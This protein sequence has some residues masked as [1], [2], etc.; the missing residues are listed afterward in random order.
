VPQLRNTFLHTCLVLG[1]WLP[2][3]LWGQNGHAF[4][5]HF[6]RKEVPGELTTW[7]ISA[8]R[9]DR[10]AAANG[11]GLL[12]HAGG[13]WELHQLPNQA[14]ARS[15]IEISDGRWMVGGQGYVGL[16]TIGQLGP[17]T[18]EDRT[19]K[20]V[21][22]M[23]SF[24]D[25]WKI[26]PMPATSQASEEQCFLYTSGFVGLLTTSGAFEL[27]DAG[28]ISRGF[29]WGNDAVGWQ[30]GDSL[31][32]WADGTVTGWEV[33]KGVLVEAALTGPN[34][35][36]TLFT[37]DNGIVRASGGDD[38]VWS[39]SDSELSQYLKANRTRC[40]IQTAPDRWW[41]GTSRGGLIETS[42]LQSIESLY[43][44]SSGLCN[45]AV[46]SISL[47]DQGNLWVATEGGI[48][49]VRLAW[50]VTRAAPS[51]IGDQPGFAS[52]HDWAAGEIYWGTSQGLYVEDMLSGEV[53][54]V[55]AVAGP[56]W[57]IEKIQEELWIGH[58]NG[59]GHLDDQRQY[60]PVIAGV[61]VWGVWTS[62]DG[63][64]YAGTFQG[65]QPIVPD[66]ANRFLAKP[67][68]T[69][70][71][72]SSR[73]MRFDADDTLWVSH[74]YK[75][76]YR[77]AILEEANEVEL[78]H[79]YGSDDGFPEP[80]DV[81]LRD[82]DGE[83][84]FATSQG[85]CE[86]NRTTNRMELASGNW[87]EWLDPQA[88]FG[89]IES[90]KRGN[91]WAFSGSV[92][93]RFSAKREQ[94]NAA[95]EVT[96]A[97]F[98]DALA[99]DGF[100]KIEFL[101]D[102]RVCSPTETGFVYID[103]ASML[104]EDD[105]PI[106]EVIQVTHLNHPNGSK[107]LPLEDLHLP[108]GSHALQIALKSQDSR[109]TGRLK[110][111]WRIPEVSAEWSTP[112][113]GQTIALN[114]LQPGLHRVE[115]RALIDASLTG[116]SQSITI[117]IEPPWFERWSVRVAFFLFTMMLFVGWYKR[118]KARLEQNH[119]RETEKQQAEIQEVESRLAEERL[120]FAQTQVQA[121]DAELASVTMN[122]VQKSQ[123]VQTVQTSL[124]KI[125]ADLTPEQRKEVDGL[126][127]LIQKGGKLDDAWEQ[128]TQQF[129]Q[130]HIDFHQRLTDRF[131]DLTK[132][133]V[134]LCSYLRMGLSTKEIASLMFVTVRAVEV[135]RSR[136]RKRLNLPQDV[137][138]TVFIQN[139]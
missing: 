65:V 14:A 6:D 32:R 43:D 135:S 79:A 137:K 5:H 100:E 99:I 77:L 129:D 49:L 112:Q 46:M 9:N 105:A 116:P 138:L 111:Q 2:L 106:A 61:G 24:E 29:S 91:L 89:L 28:E 35:E 34:G 127:H 103:P 133:D 30:T 96:R 102:G 78:L 62:P 36:I 12:T 86:W 115:F 64:R 7:D 38:S 17:C 93:L 20:I 13:N 88:G 19:Q 1:T 117:E 90:D 68:L 134:K 120:Q 67:A 45:N 15:I 75:G 39:E 21:A 41:I 80:M 42:D 97:P 66:A 124:K 98:T 128:F 132:N 72:E 121:K 33:P 23:G 94:L 56:I 57:S 3:G 10:V 63:S 69:G 125:K 131:P 27:L 4:V 11:D 51:I 123:L 101:P 58:I 81:Y 37:H 84:L 113:F 76:S 26:L 70:F 122:L 130:V 47:D 48:D 53:E 95:V 40:L 44:K 71:S 18:F 73:F 118:N 60:H 114:G 82:V 8:S 16:A 92:L 25:V 136:L 22:A 126:L 139:L 55:A 85:I 119:L 31:W 50:P 87:V 108:A 59:C 104:A 110:Y 52:L 109:W 107:A 83:M 74:P 54:R